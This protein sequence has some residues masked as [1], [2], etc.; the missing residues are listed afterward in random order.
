MKT[1]LIFGRA[2]GVWDEIDAALRLGSYDHV[3]GIGSAA[4]DY[5]GEFDCWVSFH[6]N[7]FS[8]WIEK[9]GRRGFP[10][11]KRFFSNTHKGMPVP[12]RLARPEFYPGLAVEYVFCEGGSSGLIAVM[13]AL[14]KLKAE[15]VV[16]AGVPMDIERAGYDRVDTPWAE[17]IMHRQGWTMV[18]AELQGSVRSMS[19]WTQ[20]FLG[21]LPPT[22]EWLE[23]VPRYACAS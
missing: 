9:R 2:V 8:H 16:L 20:K 17:A 18:E 21:G 22:K 5:P 4:V 1:A 19:G 12:A 14:K 10:A 6:A 23:A 7:M 11:A 13:A 3:I 15:R